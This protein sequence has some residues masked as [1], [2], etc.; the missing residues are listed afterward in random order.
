MAGHSHRPFQ[1]FAALAISRPRDRPEKACR[2]QLA[3]AVCL[4]IPLVAPL[5]YLLQALRQAAKGAVFNV[6]KKLA[7]EGVI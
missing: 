6:K 7:M 2:A 3:A 4:S 1:R 5:V